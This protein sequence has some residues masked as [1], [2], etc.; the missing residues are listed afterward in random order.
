MVQVQT[1]EIEGRVAG[2]VANIIFE[3]RKSH[4][5]A[6]TFRRHKILRLQMT[7]NYN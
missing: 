2:S 4:G 5:F 1:A 6:K 3:G 7:V